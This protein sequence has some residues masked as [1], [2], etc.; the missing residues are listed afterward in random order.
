MQKLLR[1][2]LNESRQPIV[3]NYPLG[4]KPGQF[5]TDKVLVIRR[6]EPRVPPLWRGE[7]SG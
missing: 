1:K 3:E 2:I 5:P 7:L 4:P 6:M